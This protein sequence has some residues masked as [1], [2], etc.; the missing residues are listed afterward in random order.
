MAR[1]DPRDPS[2][3]E[4]ESRRPRRVRRPLTAP[5]VVARVAE[6][7]KEDPAMNKEAISERLRA[8]GMAASPSTVGRII[9]RHALFFGD[10]PLHALKRRAGPPLHP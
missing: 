8:E 3:L 6:L 2:S 10:R 4:E 9:S 5:E 1:F 7:R